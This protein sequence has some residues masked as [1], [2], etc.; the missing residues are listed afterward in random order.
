MPGPGSSVGAGVGGGVGLA[1]GE[2]VCAQPHVPSTE[3]QT[4]K[5]GPH[6]QK[7]GGHDNG[8]NEQLPVAGTQKPVEV[9]AGS[10][11]KQLGTGHGLCTCVH[12]P[13][14]G[15]QPGVSHLPKLSGEHTVGTEP[16]APLA[17]LHT[18][19]LHKSPEFGHVVLTQ[20]PAVALQCKHW[21]HGCGD[22]VV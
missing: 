3:E 17:V 13:V 8:M 21:F 15:S 22:G 4:G 20:A 1:V 9:Y 14:L 11:M 5:L 12:K 10:P 16:H 6:G 18:F 19:G 2:Q 7:D